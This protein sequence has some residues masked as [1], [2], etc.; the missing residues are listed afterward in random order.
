MPLSSD[1][2][3]EILAKKEAAKQ[4]KSR[5]SGSRTSSGRKLDPNDRSYQA[6]F[7]LNH[8][9]IDHDTNE[10]LWCENENCSDPREKEHGQTVVEVN[11]RKMCR[12]CFVEGWLLSNPAQVRIPE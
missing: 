9:M 12:F 7:S 5:A 4:K 11:G 3:K 6:W 1:R 8:M 10:M 2:I